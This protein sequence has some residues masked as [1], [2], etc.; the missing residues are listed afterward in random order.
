MQK[1][2]VTDAEAGKRPSCIRKGP[3]GELLAGEELLA[4]VL[5]QVRQLGVTDDQTVSSLCYSVQG[6]ERVDEAQ[7]RETLH[8]H[9]QERARAA[10]CA[11]ED[12]DADLLL[13]ASGEHP[14]TAA[15]P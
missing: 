12:V 13:L 14:L 4:H 9:R 10:C 11:R 7:L 8:G 1:G 6:C 5:Q 3:P 2:H 15:C